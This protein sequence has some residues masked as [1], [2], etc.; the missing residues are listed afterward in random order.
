M[1]SASVGTVRTGG[2][3]P[4]PSAG[5]IHGTQAASTLGITAAGAGADGMIHGTMIRGTRRSSATLP[6]IGA[7]DTGIHGTGDRWPGIRGTGIH[8]TAR[9]ACTACGTGTALGE[10]TDLMACT[11]CMALTDIT[12]TTVTGACGTILTMATIQATVGITATS[13]GTHRA[14]GLWAQAV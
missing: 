11:A 12:D 3:L 8:G 6:S 13:T 7:R 14:Q 4:Y 9:T 1:A 2:D 5:G 10:C